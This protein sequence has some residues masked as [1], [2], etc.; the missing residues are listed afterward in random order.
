MAA[1][2]LLVIDASQIALFQGGL[3][4]LFDRRRQVF[5]LRVNNRPAW[6]IVRKFKTASRAPRRH[7]VDRNADT[8]QRRQQ[9]RGEESTPDDL[10]MIRVRKHSRLRRKILGT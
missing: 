3:V 10:P 8:N 1:P 7:G 6:E 9:R 4:P 5:E 2:Q